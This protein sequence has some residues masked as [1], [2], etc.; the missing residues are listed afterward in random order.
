M[1]SFFA[2]LHIHIGANQEGRPVKITASANL[3]FTNIIKECLK[4]KGIDLA[5]VVDCAAPGVIKEIEQLNSQGEIVELPEG[6]FL[7][8]DRVTVIL[9]SEVEV[10]EPGG[11]VSHQVA[12]F[13]FFRGLKE[14][15]RLMS[16]YITN[17]ELS[18]QRAA[19]SAAE[20]LAVVETMG[21]VLIP[22]HAFTPFKSVYGNAADRLEKL[23]GEEGLAAIPAIELGLSADTAIA[24]R[25]AELQGKSFLSNSDAHS[26]PK[27]A[28]E[29]NLIQM[30]RPNFKELMLALNRRQE[31]KILANYGLDPKLGKYHRTFCHKCNRVAESEPPVLVCQHC[32]ES[33]DQLVKGVL[34]RVVTIEDYSSP[35]HP[36]H[37]PPYYYQVALDYIPQISPAIYQR[38][39]EVFGNE[40]TVLHRASAEELKKAVGWEIAQNILLAREGKLLLTSG[41]G[42]HYGKVKGYQSE[43]QQLELL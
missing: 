11:G 15:S 43:H 9:G 29:Y 21:G 41:G 2:D 25:L 13:P 24:D 34:D 16:R 20:L 35:V 32:G 42:G 12:Y 40:M 33:G 19:L 37:R 6:G 30:E 4:K 14:F 3:T 10:V 31:R 28:R 22:A 8:K 1:K 5:G 17:I 7:H 36:S 26:L 23:V 27:I 38:L 18:S 39:L